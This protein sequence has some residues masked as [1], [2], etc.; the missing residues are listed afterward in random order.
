MAHHFGRALAGTFDEQLILHDWVSQGSK[1]PLLTVASGVAAALAAGEDNE[2]APGA[3]GLIG[4]EA[5][6]ACSRAG[7]SFRGNRSPVAHPA[8]A[9]IRKAIAG[10]TN[11]FAERVGN[12]APFDPD[13]AKITPGIIDWDQVA[14]IAAKH[15]FPV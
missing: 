8:S 12:R 13:A 7:G 11:F 2:G 6:R 5:G 14:V 4:G 10:R 3:V 15:L 9:K 1:P